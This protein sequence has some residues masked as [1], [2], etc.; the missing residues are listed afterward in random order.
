MPQACEIP[1]PRTQ[2]PSALNLALRRFGPFVGSILLTK[3]LSLVTIP[4]VTHHLQPGDYGRLELISSFVEL[5][6]LVMTFGLADTLFRHAGALHTQASRATTA[7]ILTI[8]ILAALIAG[9]LLQLVAVPMMA[10]V[11]LLGVDAGFRFGLLA[12]TLTGLIEMPLAWLRLHQRPGQYFIAV[13]LRAIAQLT[14]LVTTLSHGL[15]VAGVLG[16]N[17]LIDVICALALIITI[18]RRTGFGLHLPVV[19]NVVSYGLPLVGGGLAMFVLGTCDRWILSTH[20]SPESIAIYGLALKLALIVPLLLQPYALWWNAQRIKILGEAGGIAKTVTVSGF[21]FTLLFCS[22][23]GLCLIAP[24]LVHLALPPSYAGA[25][26]FLPWVVLICV[27]NESSTLLNAGTYARKTG[28]GVMAINSLAALFTLGL[29]L[30]LIPRFGVPGAILST[31]LGHSL[32]LGLYIYSSQRAVFIPY[33]FTKILILALLAA[34]LIGWGLSTLGPNTSVLLAF[35]APLM[36]IAA[37][38]GLGLIK[39]AELL[40]Q[41]SAA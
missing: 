20:V 13:S 15:G 5:A 39:P 29:Y 18:A 17:A 35:I 22:A 25:L 37:S 12:A 34:N 21:G 23:I 7:S 31:V 9:V 26:T 14:L 8:A 11:P 2:I 38:V 3:G 27:L 32:R 10:A 19:K 30:A 24:G 33:A 28:L 40:P 36:L 1:V 6:G 4:F 16:G 41:A